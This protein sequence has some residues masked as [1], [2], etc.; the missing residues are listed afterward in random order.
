M[1]AP[2]AAA[3]IDVRVTPSASA[4]GKTTTAAPMNAA[5]RSAAAPTRTSMD[6]TPRFTASASSSRANAGF[7]GVAGEHEADVVEAAV[8]DQRRRFNERR[9]A[10]ARREPRRRQHD[11]LVRR[12]APGL[13]NVGDPAPAHPFGLKLRQIQIPGGRP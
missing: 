11:P 12:D 13:A 10:A 6:W 1:S 2:I 9:L 7:V 5:G 4:A 8:L 3:S